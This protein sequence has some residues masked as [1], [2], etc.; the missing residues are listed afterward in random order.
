MIEVHA[1]KW[2]LLAFLAGTILLGVVAWFMAHDPTPRRA[3]THFWG[4]A[5][6]LLCAIGVV[7]FT[8][9]LLRAG[10]RLIIS[11]A[12][13]EDRTNRLG[14][15]PWSEIA[16]IEVRSISRQKFLSLSMHNPEPWVSRLPAMARWGMRANRA[17]GFSEINLVISG[18]TTRPSEV[19]EHVRCYF[20]H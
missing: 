20:K 8:R 19:A 12:G 17:L 7:A 18:L 4:W 2:K 3:G 15:I 14:L 1:S 10:P 11:D 9:E 13:I 5:G 16:S 6:V